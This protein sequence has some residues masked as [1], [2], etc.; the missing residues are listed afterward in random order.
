MHRL[1]WKIFISFWCALLV[2]AFATIIVAS[3][4]VE[5][6]RA[7]EH[8][9]HPRIRFNQYLH[10]A[11]EI[12]DQ[13]GREGLMRWL[14]ELDRREVVPLLI[15]DPDGKELLDRP[16]PQWFLDRG[17]RMPPCDF[18]APL[19]GPR[20]SR[21]PVIRLPDGTH[22]LLLPDY[23][24]LTLRR[25]MT[26]PRVIAMPILIGALVSGLV[27]F[28]LARYLTAPLARLRTATEQLAAGQLGQ[29]I[30][31][32]FG[33]RRDE[34]TELAKAFDDMA[35]RVQRLIQAQRRLLS[36]ASHELRSPLARLQVAIGLARQRSKTDL[37]PEFDRMEREADRLNELVAKLLEL[38]KLE[39][40]IDQ[41]PFEDIDLVEI[42]EEIIEDVNFESASEHKRVTL[43]HPG[44]ARAH[45][46]PALLRSAFENVL[47]NAVRHTAPNTSVDTSIEVNDKL[48]IA[49][50]DHGPGVP[51]EQIERIFQAFVRVSEAR[52]RDSGGYGLGLAIA[53]QAIRLHGGRI[54]ADNTK[55][56][57]CVSIE[58]PAA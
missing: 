14:H 26:R 13:H 11:Q 43:K 3:S 49:V 45:G 2:F 47:R 24:R 9:A 10:S 1:Y 40:G 21:L 17:Q 28:F 19:R 56:G 5:H 32:S 7:Q 18:R 35:A 57:F 31:P 53:E 37:E 33:R 30:A 52:E 41:L 34:I 20:L 42:L 39:A 8:V 50:S 23:E 58:L 15:I 38:A 29:R 4:Y 51:P 36:D 54:T 25:V 12:A 6:M 55:D 27:C 44:R 46:N 48:V 22:L 16:V